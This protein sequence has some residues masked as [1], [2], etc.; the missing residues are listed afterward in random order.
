MFK[1]DHQSIYM[2]SKKIIFLC[3]LFLVLGFAKSFAQLNP[4]NIRV[5]SLTDQQI[6]QGLNQF[7]LLGLS[8][9]QLEIRAKE[10]GFSTEQ[11]AA[12]KKRLAGMD[13]SQS[14]ANLSTGQA[15]VVNLE[16][17]PEYLNRKMTRY[18]MPRTPTD[19]AA[20]TLIFGA[21][22]FDN[23][24]LSFEPNL[25]IATPS[26]Y[27][28][29]VNDEIIIDV[30]GVSDITRKIKVNT[31]GAIRYPKYAP[32]KVA[33][34]TIE[35]ATTKIKR[36]LTKIYPGIISGKTTI[37]V[38]LGQIR[39]IKIT[40]LGEIRRPGNYTVPS[41]AT[42]MNALYASGGPN[43]LGDFRNI[44][45]VRGGKTVVKFDLYDFLLNGDLSK[46]LLLQDQDVIK[47]APYSKRVSLLGAVKKPAIFDLKENENAGKLIKY[48][49]GFSDIAYKN[50]V[51]VIRYGSK[52]KEVFT[53]KA[54]QFDKFSLNSGDVVIVDTLTNR[55]SNRATVT[56]SVNYP[57]VYGINDLPN[58]KELLFVA[59]IKENA[60]IDRAVIVRRDEQYKL[61]MLN[62][63]VADV[64]NGK[65][66]I[67]L[68][69]DD[70]IHIYNLDEI[71]EKY[72]V[73]IDG[74]VNAPGDYVF[75]DN[76]KVKDLILMAN[77]YK[78]GASL[79]KIE[80]G[81]RL[82]NKEVNQSANENQYAIIKDIDLTNQNV[83]E[84]LEYTLSPFD[85]VFVRKSFLY[86]EQIMVQIEGEVRYPGKYTLGS[87]DERI[88]NLITR[89]GGL[90]DKA[91]LEGAVLLR[92]NKSDDADVDKNAKSQKAVLLS[93]QVRQTTINKDLI[94]TNQSN[95]ILNSLYERQKAVGLELDLALKQPG[96]QQDIKLESGDKIYVPRIAETVQTFGALNIPKQM[97]YTEGMTVL[98]AVN[99]SGGFNTNAYRRKTYVIYA[100]GKV[101][102][103]TKF[104][105]VKFYPSLKRG[106]EVYVPLKPVSKRLTP[107]EVFSLTGTFVSMAALIFATINTTK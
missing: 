86:K 89:A 58:L 105:F 84:D 71:K 106:A 29:G 4:S 36:E 25:N 32:I 30:F 83:D 2:S 40:L 90:K 41:L 14:S 74:E 101:K 15:G 27:I 20:S 75:I 98:N 37:Q 12:F 104:L 68:V 1:F 23:E 46:N 78:Q 70:S 63:N 60:Y 77:G 9:A 19:S 13:M 45:L 65:E 42:I 54:E 97:I 79:Q 51:R 35:Q 67:D 6:L 47:V 16:V 107:S 34:L 24:F 10:K 62:F 88:S 55:F 73:K 103:T 64:L 50:F 82:V 39:S 80:I 38:S 92:V 76:M 96:S 100:N 99:A 8:E 28:I 61:R 72:T 43:N 57:G 53:I 3:V 95:Q 87:N 11:I 91:F 22:I 59:K 7:Q 94:D 49:G 102:K 93:N 33:G 5:E 69:R 21:N 44:E 18:A 85:Q 31:E 48:A 52:D 66:N 26:N 81:R 17:A 56:G